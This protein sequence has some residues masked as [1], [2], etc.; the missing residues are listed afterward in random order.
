M[1]RRL[2]RVDL[3]GIVVLIALLAIGHYFGWLNNGAV[4]E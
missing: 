1:G 3:I 4:V 2:T